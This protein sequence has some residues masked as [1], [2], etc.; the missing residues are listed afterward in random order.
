MGET[1]PA[2]RP[3]IQRWHLGQVQAWRNVD[4]VAGEACLFFGGNINETEWVH[5]ESAPFDAYTCH[6]R[7][8]HESQTLY[9][10][11]HDLET[12]A[13]ETT[14]LKDK[15]NPDLQDIFR[16][17]TLGSPASYSRG[18]RN[19]TPERGKN[20]TETADTSHH[21]HFAPRSPTCRNHTLL[22]CNSEDGQQ[23]EE[24]SSIQKACPRLWTIDVSAMV[25]SCVWTGNMLC[26]TYI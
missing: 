23:S 6:V 25:V 12:M 21:A 7:E 10:S 9:D 11:R 5:L 8:C 4:T 15:E 24:E 22:D 13:S 2:Y 17:S 16:Y 19:Q 26:N 14:G 18:G 3:S 20:S 1:V